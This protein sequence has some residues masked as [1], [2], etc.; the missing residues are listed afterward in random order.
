MLYFYNMSSGNL[1]IVYK[2]LA[3]PTRRK[4]L[5]LLKD[6]PKVTGDLCK[7]FKK[8]NRC[9]VMLHLKVLE[10]ANLVIVKREGRFRWNHLNVVPIQR[11][12]NRW[13]SSYAKP[14]A[15]VLEKIASTLD[16]DG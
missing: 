9:T 3:D 4:I 12:Y 8:L 16:F 13:I 5:D 1:D 15:E 10:E 7:I 6:G 2:A 11:I 14:A